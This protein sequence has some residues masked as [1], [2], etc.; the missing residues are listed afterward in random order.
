M[1]CASVPAQKGECGMHR[2]ISNKNKHPNQLVAPYLAWDDTPFDVCKCPDAAPCRPRV[3]GVWSAIKIS[4]S[5]P[6][7][8]R[9]LGFGTR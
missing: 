9:G 1:A 2:A 7:N 5:L 8:P 3:P 6:R 4:P